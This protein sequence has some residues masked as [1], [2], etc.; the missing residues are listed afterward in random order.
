MAAA[1]CL[2]NNK[3]KKKKE[4]KEM[5][6]THFRMRAR[7]K[8]SKVALYFMYKQLTVAVV[9][10]SVGSVFKW[11]FILCQFTKTSMHLIQTEATMAKKHEQKRILTY[12]EQNKVD[13]YLNR[14][15]FILYVIINDNFSY[16]SSDISTSYSYK[17]WN[18]C[19]KIARDFWWREIKK[20]VENQPYKQM[21]KIL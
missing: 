13:S 7:M 14:F 12:A 16:G 8:W 1:A 18:L 9:E 6:K 5:W 10:K 17:L 4:R 15:C 11:Q 21:N 2:N 3:V 20:P 19:T